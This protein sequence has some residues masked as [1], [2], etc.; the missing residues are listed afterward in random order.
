MPTK[1]K[2]LK[3]DFISRNSRFIKSFAKEHNK[4]KREF[5][6]KRD[7]PQLQLLQINRLKKQNT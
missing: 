1:Q 2:K 7:C 6:M 3:G 5:L 4:I